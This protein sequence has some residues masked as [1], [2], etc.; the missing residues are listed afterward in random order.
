MSS[1]EQTAMD[2]NHPWQTGPVELI[3]YAFELMDK[4]TE[5]DRRISF[6]LFD[7][8]VET[9]FKTY[10]LLPE[11]VTKTRI[12]FMDRKKHA[13]GTFHD[14]IKGIKRCTDCISDSD[15]AHIEFYHDIRNHLYHEGNGITVAQ[16]NLSGYSQVATE[17]L[18]KLLEVNLAGKRRSIAETPVDTERIDSVKAELQ[19]RL[20]E[21]RRITS[22]LVEEVEPKLILPST[23]TK[24]SEVS[25]G[26]EVANF[27]KK[28]SGLRYLIEDLIL[29]PETK[30]WLLHIITDDVSWDSPQVLENTKYLMET[31]EDPYRFYVLVLGFLYFPVEDYTAETISRN[32]DFSYVDQEEFHILGIYNSA[33]LTLRWWNH[34]RE[35]SY[36]H[37]QELL[38]KVEKLGKQMNDKYSELRGGEQ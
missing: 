29:N 36:S 31:M 15:L 3:D 20:D 12:N 24:F 38:P 11:S 19:K 16:K 30:K 25:K 37:A 7:V 1:K 35:W 8:A 34:S 14:L 28:V 23:I 5:I 26:I 33:D 9:T 17:V 18:R 2:W 27:P 10:L 6:L 4:G 32:D 22:L 13:T 21:L